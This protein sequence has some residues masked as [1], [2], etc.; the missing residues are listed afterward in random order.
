MSVVRVTVIG[1]GLIG[2]SVAAATKRAMPGF[3]VRGVDSDGAS[4]HYAREH[5]FIDEGATPERAEA[6]GWFA[7]SPDDLVVLATPVHAAEAWLER[8][9]A[10]GFSGIVTDV[11]STKRA[12][13]AAAALHGG[14]YRFVGGHPMAGSERSGVQAATPGLFDGAY[15]ILTPTDATDMD[16]YRDVHAF[17]TSLGARVISVDAAAH[18]DAVAVVSHV[19]HVAAAAL[20]DLAS[21]RARDAGADLLRLAAGGFKDMTRIA[22]GSPELWTG[23]CLDNAPA[24]AAGLEGLEKVLAEFRT[25]VAARDEQ[26]VHAWLAAAADV[27]RALPAQ[28]VPAST[29]LRELL[30]PVNDRPG[31]VGVVTTAASRAGCNIEDIEI[32]HQSEDRAVLRLVLTDEGD[33]AALMRDLQ[34]RGFSPE[35]RQLESGE[36]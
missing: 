8:L 32:D 24:L 21:A 28:W 30:V 26:A 12:V 20:V 23:I 34:G 25:A 35:I 22:S 11:G 29:R 31:V 14:G 16:A 19:P 1:L 36:S 33:A 15:Y 17:V 4:V 10:V 7:G 5:G 9:G 18:D 6:D 13:V 3:P 2:G 27:R